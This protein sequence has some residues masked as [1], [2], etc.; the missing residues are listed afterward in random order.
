M[1]DNSEKGMELME[2]PE[3]ANLSEQTKLEMEV[4]RKT[5]AA[6]AAAFEAAQKARAA[7]NAP[8]VEEDPEAVKAAA[9]A[10]PLQIPAED[11]EPVF[12]V[13]G[14]KAKS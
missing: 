13:A 9:E 10:K 12:P 1:G 3:Y 14:R 8:P 11:R 5:A 6:N 4:G 7:E 2:N